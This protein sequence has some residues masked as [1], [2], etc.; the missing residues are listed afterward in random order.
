[1]AAPVLFP[2]KII[3]NEQTLD[4]NIYMDAGIVNNN[5]SMFLLKHL[6]EKNIHIDRFLSLGN[7]QYRNHIA[8]GSISDIN[9]YS[10]YKTLEMYRIQNDFRSKTEEEISQFMCE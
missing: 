1:M 4:A 8:T 6:L 10:V 3:L 2:M 9:Y 7:M 5:C